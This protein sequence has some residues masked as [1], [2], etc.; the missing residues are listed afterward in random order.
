MSIDEIREKII[1]IIKQYNITRIV[2]FGSR[3]SGTYNENSDI[4]FIVEFGDPVSLIKLAS[5]K[6]DLED[7]LGLP[8]DVIHGPIRDTDMIE[9]GETVEIYAA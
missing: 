3:A 6:Y 7:A 1:E 5:L 4:D 9:V 8:V 2:M